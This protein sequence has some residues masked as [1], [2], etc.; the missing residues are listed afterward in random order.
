MNIEQFRKKYGAF[1][2][3]LEEDFNFII[4]CDLEDFK[5]DPE[6]KQRGYKTMSNCELF[7]QFIDYAKAI[8]MYDEMFFLSL[9][10][11]E[12]YYAY[13]EFGK[14]NIIQH[15]SDVAEDYKAKARQL[16]KI[17]EEVLK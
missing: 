14:N 4:H 17:I 12:H 3:R 5:T 7:S 16:E 6:M 9:P 10:C 13:T 2:S 15:I 1:A 8:G 11:G